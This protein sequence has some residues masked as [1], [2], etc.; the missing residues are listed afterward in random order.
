MTAR[1]AGVSVETIR[2]Y[3]REDLI[4]QPA[5]SGEG[6]RRYPP[7]T[8]TRLRFTRRAKDLG[9]SLDEIRELLRLG[10]EPQSACADVR[11]FAEEKIS[12]ID[13][14]IEALHAMRLALLDLTAACRE[15]VP[16]VCPILEA[17]EKEE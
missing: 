7:E 6:Y 17:L 10:E 8:L 3:E 12:A 11:R 4:A 1:L 5:R 9:F 14:K 13:A 2:F 15:A 16:G